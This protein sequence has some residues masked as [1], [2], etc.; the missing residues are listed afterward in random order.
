[1]R[2]VSRNDFISILWMRE[3]LHYLPSF[4]C[5]MTLKG[6]YFLYFVWHLC[7]LK[8]EFHLS[9]SPAG[10]W[11]CIV[12]DVSGLAICLVPSLTESHLIAICKVRTK[13]NKWPIT[14]SGSS[15]VGKNYLKVVFHLVKFHSWPSST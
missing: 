13:A 12:S 10:V 6:L 14:L 15:K 3:F 4:A 9:S 1:M 2:T 5:L 8:S 11:Y 7:P